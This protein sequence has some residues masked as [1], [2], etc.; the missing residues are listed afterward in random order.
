[1]IEVIGLGL[2]TFIVVPLAFGTLIVYG[3]VPIM[4][5]GAGWRDKR[6]P[7]A[8]ARRHQEARERADRCRW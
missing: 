6:Y 8:A 1:M 5:W 2:L 3:L 4:E 7:E